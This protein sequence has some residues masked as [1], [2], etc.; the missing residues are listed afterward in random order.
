MPILQRINRAFLSWTA[1]KWE[2]QNVDPDIP[3]SEA[4]SPSLSQLAPLLFCN[5]HS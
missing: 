5:V 2:I 3:N 4:H 1:N